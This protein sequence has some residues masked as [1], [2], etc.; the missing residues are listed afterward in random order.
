MCPLI[1]HES[2]TSVVKDNGLSLG[3]PRKLELSL[4]E[5]TLIE[6][7]L[8]PLGGG[9]ALGFGIGAASGYAFAMRLWQT[10][11]LPALE[12]KIDELLENL[13]EIKEDL[14]KERSR[15]RH[16]EDLLQKGD[17]EDE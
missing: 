11:K 4:M 2:T 1:G 3:G 14:D 16:I 12:Q 15:I 10:Y 5:Q 6:L 8:G 17:D 13:E 7:I 9:V